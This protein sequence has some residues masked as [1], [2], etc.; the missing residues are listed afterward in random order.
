MPVSPA[1][2]LGL[3][4]P[5]LRK[6]RPRRP[7]P[8]S[9]YAA[10]GAFRPRSA[11]VERPRIALRGLRPLHGA[12]RA[13]RTQPSAARH[14]PHRVLARGARTAPAA[15]RLTHPPGRLRGCSPC[16]PAAHDRRGRLRRRS[17]D[18]SPSA[19]STSTC[20]PRPSRSSRSPTATSACAATSTRASRTGRPARTSTASTRRV[21]LPYAEA[22]YG[23]PEAGETLINVTNGK[24]FRLLVDD[25]PFDVRYGTLEHHERMLDLRERRPAPR[26]ALDCRP[27]VRASIVRTTRLVSFVQRAVAA[28]HYEVEP[29]RRRRGSSCSPSSSPTSP[30]PSRPPTT[31]APPPRCAA[32]LRRRV[33]RPPRARSAAL[34]P[35]H[36]RQR[37]AHGRRRWTTSSTARRGR[38]TAAESEKDLARVTV[39]TELAPGRALRVVKFLAYGW[40][41]RRSMP[42][43]RDQV[44]AALAAAMHTGWDGLVARAARVPRRRSGPAPTSSSRATRRCSR[45][46]ASRCSRSCRRPPGPSS[47]AIPAKGLTGRGYD[48]H[49]FWDMETYALPV[50]TYTAPTAA[51][52]A[53]RWR[54]STLDLA[55]ARARELRLAGAAF[56]WRTISRRGVLGLL[57]RRHRRVPH[58]R[59]HR[60]RRAPLRGRDRRR[61]SSSAARA[62]ELLVE[63]ARLW[64]SLGH[65]DAA[66]SFRIDGVTGP[67]EYTALVDNNVYTNLM[68]ARNLRAAA[69]ARRAPPRQR[70]AELGVDEEE[71][72][73]WRDAADAMVVP[74][75][76]ELGV[77]PQSRG[78]H[79]LPPLGLREHAARAVPAAAALPV[80]H[81]V[82]AAR[83]S[84]RPIWSSPCTLCGDHFS[85]EQKRARLR[86]LRGHHGA[87]LVAVGVRPGDRRGRGRPPRPRL[88]LL[89]RDGASSIC[90]TSPATRTTAST[91][92]RWRAPGSSRWPAS[93]ACA[94]TATRC[95]FAP[96]LPARSR[97]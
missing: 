79:P 76:E 16:P 85:A 50:L 97:G 18:R 82:L 53:L 27:P 63:T 43:L 48:G 44:D 67:D 32:P 92:P 81:A 24:L 20:W 78:L 28:I 7:A 89:R 2:G 17:L 57:A 9:P 93:A 59:R 56:P 88:R 33:P 84:S 87:R 60:R 38:V 65:H 94:T 37:P 86:V 36:A 19:S 61:R 72:A 34:V 15:W 42:A 55:R 51:R 66:G 5:K 95:A 31:R 14:A 73:A 47:R 29:S 39:S 74:F 3:A 75:D 11:D 71:I 77:T 23:Y 41:S 68:A 6:T 62:L 90:A 40:S 69:D 45:R 91:S 8:T 35:Q 12:R 49:T 96:R 58:Q 13:R 4:T 30:C 1:C 80:L 25:E 21:P 52:D 46:C 54:H 64:R 26:G 10:S 83:S 22:G 70:A